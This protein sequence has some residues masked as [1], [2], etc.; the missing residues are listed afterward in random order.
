MQRGIV[1]L[2]L[3]ACTCLIRLSE[4]ICL[5]STDAGRS[6]IFLYDSLFAYAARLCLCFARRE[7]EEMSD[8]TV[9]ARSDKCC[10]PVVDCSIKC[11]AMSMFPSIPESC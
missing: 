4:Q 1:F 8:S 10:A 3:R 5:M 11:C 6:V 2:I 9:V 7:R